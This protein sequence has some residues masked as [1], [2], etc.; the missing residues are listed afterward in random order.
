[1]SGG[2]ISGQKDLEE[3]SGID[4]LPP[5]GENQTGKDAMGLQSAWGAGSETN[6]PKDNQVSQ[7]L[8]GLIIGR[9]GSGSILYN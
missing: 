1:M 2:R 5:G 6:L 4:A 8:F 7:G 3:L 9:R